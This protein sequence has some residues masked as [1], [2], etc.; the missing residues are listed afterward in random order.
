MLS[1]T[2]CV[3]DATAA[4]AAA[5]VVA[6]PPSSAAAP[7]KTD[8]SLH[9][10]WATD[11]EAVN[12]SRW[13]RTSNERTLPDGTV[14]RNITL[15]RGGTEATIEQ[16][17]FAMATETLLRFKQVQGVS[18]RL[19]AI[20][21]L[22]VALPVPT[23]A[24]ATLHGF[25]GSAAS[26]MDYSATELPLL[27]GAASSHVPVGGRSSNGVLPFFG[28]HFSSSS[29]G[30]GGGAG[31]G[32]SGVDGG[33][34][35]SVGWSGSW[36]VNVSRSADGHS[37]RVQAGLAYF[38]ASLQPGQSFRGTRILAANYTGADVLEGYNVHRHAL[39]KHFLRR[40]SRGNVRGG[41]VSSW[42]AQT[43]QNNVDEQNMLDMIAGVTRPPGSRPRG[44]T[45]AGTSVAG[46]AMSATG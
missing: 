38:D 44:S 31:A 1:A 12:F 37:V 34:V 17:V 33:F 2:I 24:E 15:E 14:E 32:G 30:G 46:W 42:T 19:S 45:L 5:A 21:T 28:I 35:F 8:E 4:A 6:G 10:S 29:S 43:Y 25:S 7:A 23:G 11:G 36:Q 26:A 9:C 41:L 27:P 18:P 39:S 13:R 16:R 20:N 22:D 40:D 3:S